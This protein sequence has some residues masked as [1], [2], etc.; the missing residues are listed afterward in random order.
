M[1]APGGWYAAP[2]TERDPSADIGRNIRRRRQ[3]LGLSLD[4]L[5]R[6]S[7]VSSTMLSE[8]ERAVK[9]PTVKLAYQIARALGCSLTD[10]LE[11][12]PVAP[13]TVV[14]ASQRRT[15][16]DPDSQV[17]RHGL[18][19]ELLGKRVEVAWYELPPGQSTGE[20]SANRAGVVELVTVFTGELTFLL[21]GERYLLAAGDSVSYGPQTTCEY[22]NEGDEPCTVLL[23]SDSSKSA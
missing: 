2:V 5:A 3:A 23:L 8:V 1:R 21:G 15:L 11:A 10:L 22:R 12:V 9:N 6:S 4:A 7:G 17:T 14:R 19:S 20:L 18:T 16:V 13:V